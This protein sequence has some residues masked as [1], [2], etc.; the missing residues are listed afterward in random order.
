MQPPWQ[1]SP[2]WASP[3]SQKNR[4]PID[5]LRVDVAI[6]NRTGNRS[7][8]QARP[9]LATG[10]LA[11]AIRQAGLTKDAN[12]PVSAGSHRRAGTLVTGALDPDG[13]NVGLQIWITDVR[14][15]GRPWAVVPVAGPPD[16][17]AG[18]VDRIRPQ[19]VGAVA[20]LRN[21]SYASLFPIANPPPA[22]EAY[23]EFLEGVKLQ[24]QGQA[25]DALQ[26]YRL[27]TA[28]DSSFTWPLVHGGLGSLYGVRADFTPQVDSLVHSLSLIRDRLP[29][30][31]IHLLDHILAVR[32]DDWGAS[33]RAIRAAA[34]LAPHH[35][36]FMLAN[37][38]TQQNRPREAAE[39]LTRPGMDS[40][41]RVSIQ[42]YWNV[43]TFSLHLLDEHRSELEQA[44]HA[45]LNQP[46]SGSALFQEIRALAA[47]G[48]LPGP[49]PSGYAAVPPERRVVHA[50]HCHGDDRS[51]APGPR[52]P[53]SRV[54]NL[55]ARSDLV[56]IPSQRRTGVPGMAGVGG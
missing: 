26:H 21:S 40:I 10:R 47:L 43:L 29:P 34:E 8:D 25:A 41:Y 31:Q 54:A 16:S 35:Y 18:A 17:I 14:R 2:W 48:R 50:G 4:A 46:E 23:Q 9:E 39:V 24:S 27:A 30:L 56:S 45:R 28:I 22:F 15:G 52:A 13:E 53:G 6:E 7:L 1:C 36:G 33:Y 19:V 49:G 12:P 20:V 51:R 37:M 44:R 11:D 5:P 42:G 38:A 3:A 32:T 55:R